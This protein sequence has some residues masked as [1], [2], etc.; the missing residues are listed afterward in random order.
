MSIGTDSLRMCVCIY[1]TA[2]SE[3]VLS[4]LTRA[5]QNYNRHEKQSQQQ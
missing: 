3:D 5:L 1:G 2:S 4:K